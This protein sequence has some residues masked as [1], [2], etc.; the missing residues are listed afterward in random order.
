[1]IRLALPKGRNLGPA[2]KAF[3]AVGLSFDGFEERKLR[4]TL[5]IPKRSERSK[6]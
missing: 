4:Q 5:A 1:M 2:M 3:E 6:S